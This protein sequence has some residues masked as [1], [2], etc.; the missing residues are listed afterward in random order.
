LNGDSNSWTEGVRHVTEKGLREVVAAQTRISDIDGEHGRLWYVG[1]EISDL[2]ERATFEEIV[3][4]LHHLELPNEPQLETLNAFLVDEREPSHFQTELMP[5]LA[6][7]TSPMSMLRTS[8]SSASTYDPDGWDFSIEANLRKALRLVA[9]MPSFI[10][11]YHRARSGNDLIPPNPKL[12]HAANFLTMLL[13]EEP[14]EVA[15]HALDTT[16]ILYADHT[17]NASTFTARIIASTLSDLHSAITGAI[18]ALKGPLHGGANEEAMK[19]LEEVGEPANAE[20][21]VQDRLSRKEKVMGFGHA[22]YRVMDPRATVLRDLARRTAER[23]GT[24]GLFETAEAIE[25]VTFEEK[26]LYPNVD[27][28]AAVVY[29]A[30]GIPTDLMTPIFALARTAGWTAHVREQYA[31]NKVIRPGSEYIG[32]RDRTYVPIGERA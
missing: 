20:R 32:P 30:L 22:V 13:G 3:Y 8:V 31:D 29:H 5:T 11:M 15:T 16:F 12:S 7:Q 26:G 18:G 4:L 14:D 17:M 23:A 19:M 6:Q 9:L 27:F 25:Q 10:A 28:Y 21:Y 1:Y 24:T 2:A